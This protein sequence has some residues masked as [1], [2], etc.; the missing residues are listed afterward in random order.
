MSLELADV[1]LDRGEFAVG[2]LN[3][4]FDAA[5][6][7]FLAVALDLLGSAAEARR[8]DL[9]A[10]EVVGYTWDRGEGCRVELS[11]LGCCCREELE[12]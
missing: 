11:D 1:E 12:S 8:V 9:E 10:F 3:A 5:G 6:A 7:R 2:A 4:V